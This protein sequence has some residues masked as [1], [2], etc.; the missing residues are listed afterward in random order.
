MPE[1]GSSDVSEA[2][3]E[4]ER[5]AVDVWRERTDEFLGWDH[6]G[7]AGRKEG[8]FTWTVDVSSVRSGVS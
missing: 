4:G 3:G 5:A 8:S 1:V 2:V 7:V 6:G